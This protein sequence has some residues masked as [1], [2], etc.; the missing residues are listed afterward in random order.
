MR[1]QWPMVTAFAKGR[2]A[3]AERL[4]REPT[5]AEIRYLCHEMFDGTEP[6]LIEVLLYERQAR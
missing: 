4:G 6:F 5:V 2:A 3:L 1:R